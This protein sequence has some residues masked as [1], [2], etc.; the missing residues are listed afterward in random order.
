MNKLNFHHLLV[1]E[2][3]FMQH[4]SIPEECKA[5]SSIE[6]IACT[7]LLRLAKPQKQLSM[8]AR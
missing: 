3:D 1:F 4:R 8:A 7:E 2:I 5:Y 6:E